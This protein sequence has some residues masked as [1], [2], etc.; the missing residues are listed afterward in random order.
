M[1]RVIL[2]TAGCITF[3]IDCWDCIATV[4]FIDTAHNIVAYLETIWKILKP[5]GYWINLGQY[6]YRHLLEKM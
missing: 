2:C 6:C 4:F 5:N 3:V 1:S